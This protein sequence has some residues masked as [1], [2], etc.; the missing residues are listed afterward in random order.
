MIDRKNHPIGWA[1]LLYDLGDAHEHL[2]SLLKNLSENSE[3][4][5][6]QFRI[7]LGHV[8]AHLNRAW[9]RRNIPEDFDTLEWNTATQFPRD[10][11]PCG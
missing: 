1:H 7:D 11:E 5:G 4:S 2:S 3:Y 6:E 8:Y 9:Y 10:L